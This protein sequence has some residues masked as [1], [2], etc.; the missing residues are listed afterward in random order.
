[1]KIRRGS[2]GLN[3]LHIEVDD[4]QT[5]T[6]YRSDVRYV[7]LAI[8]NIPY[9]IIA[10]DYRFY[11]V[12]IRAFCEDGGCRRHQLVIGLVASVL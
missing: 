7:A 9:K 2:L 4:P 8:P 12:H 1:M 3:F 6:S 5:D 11:A 10:H